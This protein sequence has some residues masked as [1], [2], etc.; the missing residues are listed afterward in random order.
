M[1]TFL[2]SILFVLDLCFFLGTLLDIL[3]SV[4]IK[5]VSDSELILKETP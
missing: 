2:K 1:L 5:Q 3:Y 4:C